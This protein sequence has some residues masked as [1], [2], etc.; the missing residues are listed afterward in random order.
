MGELVHKSSVSGSVI[1][2]SG[3]P[4]D[5]AEPTETQKLMIR[6]LHA[7]RHM[8]L[9]PQMNDERIQLAEESIRTLHDKVIAS[10]Y[11]EISGAANFDRQKAAM[12]FEAK[13]SG[14]ISERTMIGIG[15][16]WTNYM[17]SCFMWHAGKH[18]KVHGH[19]DW[20]YRGEVPLTEMRYEHMG[21]HF[22]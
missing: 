19:T 12:S 11:N 14:A 20:N 13:I 9:L 10:I 2:G 18:P 3:V 8:G 16:V 4:A 6:F 1:S 7:A 15:S 5:T 17:M 22:A 21:H